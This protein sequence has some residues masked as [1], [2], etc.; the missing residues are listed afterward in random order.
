MNFKAQIFR[1]PLPHLLSWQ[2]GVR[3]RGEI[4]EY[5]FTAAQGDQ[6]VYQRP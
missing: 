4:K 1:L 6:R 3:I 5:V 2:P